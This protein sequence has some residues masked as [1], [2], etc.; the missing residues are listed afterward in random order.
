[1]HEPREQQSGPDAG[2]W[3]PLVADSVSPA[4]IEALLARRVPYLHVPGFLDPSW[5]AEVIRRFWATMDTLPDHRSLS[6]GPALFD[7]LV[8]PVEF[9]VDANDQDEYFAHVAEDAPR[10]RGLF[11]GGDDPL[12]K[13]RSAWRTA[14]WIEVPAVEDEH[15]RYH[16]DAIWALRRAAAPPHVDSYEHDRQIALSRFGRRFNYNVYLQNADSGG[17]FVLYNYTSSPEAPADREPRALDAA[18][19]AKLLGGAERLEHHPAPGDLVI[20]DAMQYHEVTQVD[21]ARTPRIQIHSCMLVD[22]ATREFLFFV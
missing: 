16:P 8:K 13:M 22:E 17:F 10:V 4:A 9:F 18:W 2:S 14:G 3:V 20:F 15:R 1:M 12:D 5:C 19:T 6:M 11:A 7:T 21:G